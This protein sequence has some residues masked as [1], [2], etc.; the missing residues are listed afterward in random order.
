MFEKRL[1]TLL[2][3][4]ELNCQAP[5]TRSILYFSFVS[6]ILLLPH[7][8]RQKQSVCVCIWCAEIATALGN[9]KERT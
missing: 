6:T 4:F 5:Y 7:T 9:T 1:Y 2:C 3:S 8:H